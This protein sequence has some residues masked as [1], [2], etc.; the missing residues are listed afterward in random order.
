M[1]PWS[2]LGTK[3]REASQLPFHNSQRIGY[4]APHGAGLGPLEKARGRSWREDA[5]EAGIR[6]P[7]QL[8]YRTDFQSFEPRPR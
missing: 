4:M 5:A 3:P 1:A 8:L 2:W 6:A 7:H